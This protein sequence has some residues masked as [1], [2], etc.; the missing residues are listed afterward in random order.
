MALEQ[1]PRSENLVLTAQDTEYSFAIPPAV[2]SFDFQAREARDIR[3]AFISDGTF[4]LGEYFTLKSGNTYY[5]DVPVEHRAFTIYFRD[6]A[7]AGTVIELILWE[8]KG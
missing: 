5:K 3:I 2:R 7:N 8:E 6:P 1:I 4:T